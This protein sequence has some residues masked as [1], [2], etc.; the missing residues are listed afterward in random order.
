LLVA[1]VEVKPMALAMLEVEQG[2]H[3]LEVVLVEDQIQLV[4]EL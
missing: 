1:E 4:L 3:M 2:V